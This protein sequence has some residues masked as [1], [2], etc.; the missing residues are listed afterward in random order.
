MEYVAF[1]VDRANIGRRERGQAADSERRTAAIAVRWNR[2]LL[3]QRLPLRICPAYRHTGNYWVA[4]EESLPIA[5]VETM[6]SGTLSRDFA[7][8]TMEEFLAWVAAADSIKA[9]SEVPPGRR[10]TPGAVMDLNTALVPP[11]ALA[12][13]ERWLFDAY[14]VPRVRMVWKLD[15]EVPGGGKLDSSPE[16]REG[17]WGSIVPLMKKQVGGRW[18]AR[19][20]STLKGVAQTVM[21]R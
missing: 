3:S 20:M 10:A 6:L 12:S 1:E 11:P 17:G 13:T 18:T 5:D 21:L 4:A 8:F 19:A 16:G 7:V 15:V 9:P 2:L 14:A